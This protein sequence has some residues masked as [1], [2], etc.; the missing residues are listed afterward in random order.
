MVSFLVNY[1]WVLV[2]IAAAIGVIVYF[3]NNFTKMPHATQLDKIREWMLY[4]VIQAEKT[5]GGGTG[6]VKLRYVYD[7]FISKFPSVAKAISFETFSMLVDEALQK[8]RK[9]LDTNDK[10][11][12]YVEEGTT[13][14]VQVK[15]E[16]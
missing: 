14:S 9:I 10:V 5:L 3:I 13:T 1:W 7:M 16:K 2:V 4:A 15:E 12:A 8:M 6:Q 11:K